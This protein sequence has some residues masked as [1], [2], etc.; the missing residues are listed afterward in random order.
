MVERSSRKFDM[1]KA[2]FDKF[3]NQMSM[4]NHSSVS[5]ALS[6]VY[7][8]VVQVENSLP[9]SSYSLKGGCWLILFEEEKRTSR[10]MCYVIK[11]WAT[12]FTFIKQEQSMNCNF[13]WTSWGTQV[14]ICHRIISVFEY[15]NLWLIHLKKNTETYLLSH[16]LYAC[17]WVCNS[18]KSYLFHCIHDKLNLSAPPCPFFEDLV[19]VHCLQY[20]L[21]FVSQP[22]F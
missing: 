10:A 21:H 18:L 11:A 14:G 6:V 4:M 9:F 19:L 13:S 15:L 5:C 3:L 20:I 2:H 7:M 17:V 16:F 1:G 12:L 22:N 8:F